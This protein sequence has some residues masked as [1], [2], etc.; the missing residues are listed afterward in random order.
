MYMQAYILYVFKQ[1]HRIMVTPKTMYKN[2]IHVFINWVFV[3]ITK[4]QSGGVGQAGTS[5]SFDTGEQSIKYYY[6]CQS[7]L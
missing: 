2:V 6:Y 1:P 7:S 3:V 4:G 5:T